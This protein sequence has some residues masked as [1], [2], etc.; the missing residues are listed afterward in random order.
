MLICSVLSEDAC[1]PSAPLC[2]RQRWPRRWEMDRHKLPFGFFA[3]GMFGLSWKGEE[4]LSSQDH[5]L[6]PKRPS[7]FLGLPTPHQLLPSL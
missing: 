3:V 1:S 4:S 5:Y 2:P 7:V 6:T